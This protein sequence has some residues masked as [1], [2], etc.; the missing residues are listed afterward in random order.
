M[1]GR[2]EI[3]KAVVSVNAVMVDGKAM[4]IA[5]FDQIPYR[6]PS[7]LARVGLL[8][9]DIDLIGWVN[10]EN[11][12][13]FTVGGILYKTKRPEKTNYNGHPCELHSHVGGYR[14][15]CEDCRRFEDSCDVLAQH[16]RAAKQVYV[17][18]GGS[19]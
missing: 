8:P 14:I 4:T 9:V 16:L 5:V 12:V 18:V 17:A 13:L 6:D 11:T 7:T 3:T 2:V 15:S 1:S 10:R 19:R